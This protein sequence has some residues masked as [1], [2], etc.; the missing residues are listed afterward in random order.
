MDGMMN[1]TRSVV[2]PTQTSKQQPAS[3]QSQQMLVPGV[4]AVSF[5]MRK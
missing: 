2:C 3:E 5:G 1:N 4:R